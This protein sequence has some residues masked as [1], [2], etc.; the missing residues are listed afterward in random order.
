[1]ITEVCPDGIE[2]ELSTDEDLAIWTTD[3]QVV[4]TVKPLAI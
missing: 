3:P 2:I 1:M 4:A